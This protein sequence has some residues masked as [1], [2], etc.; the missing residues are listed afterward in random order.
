MSL[1]I[2]ISSILDMVG[3]TPLIE[4]KK[5]NKYLNNNV[6]IFAK[7]EFSNPGSS[8]KDRPAKKMILEAIKSK[9]FNKN[10][11]LIDATSGNTGV[12]YAWIC[13]ALGLELELVMPENA[14]DKKRIIEA[15][16]TKIVYTDPLEGSDGAI[17][18][19]RKIYNSNP[20]KYFYP[21]Q[22]NNSNNWLAHY[23][24]TAN[25]IWQQ[26]RGQLTH[27]IAGIGTGGTIVGVGRRL[28]E[29]NPDI[30]I[31]GVEPAT[32]L[33]GLEGLK[34]MASSI[35]PGIYDASVHNFKINVYTEDA[36]E[37]CCRLAREEGILVG[38]SSGAALFASIEVATQLNEGI[39]VT[40]F[41]DSGERYLK[42]QFW[43]EV[44][45]QF[46]WFK[47]SGRKA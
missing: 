9:E 43:D 4:L 3:N 21:D 37:M 29:L 35:V 30:V 7:A 42:T 16:G 8:I 19:A 39:I 27:F 14:S 17:L 33:H 38:F 11:T 25:E 45:C 23:Q 40:V 22:Y 20:E 10:K 2:Q 32:A 13:S 47:K 15:F 12:A 44:L 18:E 6:K 26:T 41:P 34:H 46:H 31:V 24:T 28:K 1:D 5:I 36:Y